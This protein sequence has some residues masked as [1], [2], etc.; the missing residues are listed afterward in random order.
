MSDTPSEQKKPRFH[1]L[2]LIPL[3]EYLGRQD[4]T[5]CKGFSSSLGGRIRRAWKKSL[6]E[7]K[8]FLDA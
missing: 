4:L 2:Q 3:N 6:I 1:G 7:V 5:T 8:P